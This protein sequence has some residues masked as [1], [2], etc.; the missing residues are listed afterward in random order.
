MEAFSTVLQAYKASFLKIDPSTIPEIVCVFIGSRL[1]SPESSQLSGYDGI[2]VVRSKLDIYYLVSGKH[3]RQCLLDMIGITIEEQADPYV[4]E[5]GSALYPEFDGICISG[6]DEANAS[7]SMKR[8]VKILSLECFA[9]NKTSL[10]LISY[11]DRRVYDGI[12]LGNELFMK[13]L[14]QA[15]TLDQQSVVLHDQLLYSTPHMENTKTLASFGTT[16]ELLVSGACIYGEDPFGKEMKRLMVK[17]YISVTSSSPSLK[18]FIRYPRFQPFYAEWLTRELADLSPTYLVTPFDHSS[19]VVQDHVILLG[20]TVQARASANMFNSPYTRELPV[21]V[22]TQ[23]DEGHVI[24]QE[25]NQALF[26]HNSTSYRATTFPPDPVEIFV[27]VTPYARDEL[28]GAKM[29]LEYFPR[30][31]VPRLAQSGE[32]LYPYFPG[33]TQSD[34]RLS[35]ITNGRKDKNLLN[36]ILHVELVKAQ[37]TLCAYRRSLSLTSNTPN[38]RQNIQRL[39]HDRLVDD[40]RMRDF[41]GQGITLAGE[42]LS[43]DRLFSLNWVIN[44]Q[45]YPSLREAFDEAKGIIAP[46]SAPMV[47]CPMV[48]GFGD[49]HSGN[50]MYIPADPNGHTNDVRWID[51][52]VAGF[53]PLMLDLAKPI[54]NTVFFETLEQRLMPEHAKLDLEYRV[55]QKSNTIVVNFSPRIDSL[56]Q[57]ILDIKLRYLVKPIR[58][59]I[60]KLGGQLEDHVPLLSTALFL[61]ATLGRN[62]AN[63]E[64]AFL[65]NFATGFILRKA[66]TWLQFGFAIEKLGFDSRSAK[67]IEYAYI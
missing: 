25:S 17:H 60:E 44:N 56:T 21:E 55:N 64:Q 9:G 6:Y 48:F 11:K 51:Y 36:S 32:L 37:D 18:S 43:F 12:N 50:V 54:Y 8:S 65:I 49:A 63:N 2:I 4:P 19:E 39:F 45:H 66:Q 10:N 31:T 59:E 13:K 27:K 41:Y 35:Y 52:E 61:C 58:D 3:R 7:T 1:H 57:A 14:Q 16:A 20:N 24:K 22:V 23:F 46:G 26:S 38:P 53:H 15:T 33:T 5:P 42:Y 30:I 62:C 67:A 40:R 28:Q 34:A 29:A 47:S